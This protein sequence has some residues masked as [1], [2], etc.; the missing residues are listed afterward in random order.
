MLRTPLVELCLQIKL[1]AL[2]QIKPFLS[3]VC[4]DIF[5]LGFL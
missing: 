2:G 4:G 1:L 5:K 3:K